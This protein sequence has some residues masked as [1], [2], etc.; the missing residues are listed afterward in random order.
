MIMIRQAPR[1]RTRA[2]SHHRAS[3]SS[4]FLFSAATVGMSFDD[5]LYLAPVCY[6]RLEKTIVLV[7]FI[8]YHFALQAI[9]VEFLLVESNFPLRDSA[10]EMSVNILDLRIGR[11]VD[12]APN[13][14]VEIVLLDLVQVNKP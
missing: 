7:F 6:R 11:I 5:L 13:V 14:E 9:S 1:L 2:L 8:E 12:V 10:D 3:A 4:I